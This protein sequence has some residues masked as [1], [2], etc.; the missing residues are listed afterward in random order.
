MGVNLKL[1]WASRIRI[2]NKQTARSHPCNLNQ[3]KE[4]CANFQSLLLTPPCNLK[5]FSFCRRK[6]TTSA[7]MSEVDSS[8]RGEW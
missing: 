6:R 5:H 8:S 7:N 1:L 4:I 3:T 2:R